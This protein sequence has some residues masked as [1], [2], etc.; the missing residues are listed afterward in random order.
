MMNT[1]GYYL[2]RDAQIFALHEQGT[3]RTALCAKFHI[4]RARIGYILDRAARQKA[5]EEHPH[6]SHGLSGRLCNVINNLDIKSREEVRLAVISGRLS[7]K[8]SARVRNYG[9]K[10]E[11]EVCAWLGIPVPGSD[12]QKQNYAE[13]DACL[14]VL[15]DRAR[16]LCEKLQGSPLQPW[17]G[18]YLSLV[19][20]IK[21]S[22]HCL[23]PIGLETTLE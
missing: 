21:R 12:A 17:T 19:E 14:R 6:W 18:E 22:E 23:P 13:L 5:Q 20:E 15:R 16:S 10:M 3:T 8:P 4:S 11:K 2:K 9:K 7:P 1:A